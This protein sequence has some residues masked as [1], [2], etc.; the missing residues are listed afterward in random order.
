M[1]SRLDVSLDVSTRKSANVAHA[2]VATK[3][4][5]GG[6]VVSG[7]AR[8]LQRSEATRIVQPFNDI[9]ISVVFGVVFGVIAVV[10]DDVLLENGGSTS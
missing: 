6:D 9:I 7:V 2:V 3:K 1:Q 4:G 5:E 10:V 8:E